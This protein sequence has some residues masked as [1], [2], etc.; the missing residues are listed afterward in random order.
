MFFCLISSPFPSNFH[1]NLQALIQEMG[2]ADWYRLS[3][4]D[5]QKKLVELKMRERRLRRE[6][7]TD[8]LAQLLGNFAKDSDSKN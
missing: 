5:R 8:E 4:L 2:E 3:D 7:L 1:R 6:G